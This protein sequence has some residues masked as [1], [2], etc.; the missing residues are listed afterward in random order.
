MFLEEYEW[1]ATIWTGSFFSLNISNSILTNEF[2]RIQSDSYNTD[3]SIHRTVFHDLGIVPP[4][5]EI[6]P[7]G[8]VDYVDISLSIGLLSIYFISGISTITIA[9]GLTSSYIFSLTP[10]KQLMR[11]Y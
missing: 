11:C 10:K 9:T 2:N 8:I 5:V 4:I 7:E 1:I 3:P 6:S